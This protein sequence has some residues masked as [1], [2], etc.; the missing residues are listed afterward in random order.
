VSPD[1]DATGRVRMAGSGPAGTQPGGG[2]HAGR[3]HRTRIRSLDAVSSWHAH[4]FVA[5]LPEVERE[6]DAALPVFADHAYGWPLA[7][8]AAPSASPAVGVP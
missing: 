5:E 8:E 3:L 2:S 1:D 7:D 6:L 4:V